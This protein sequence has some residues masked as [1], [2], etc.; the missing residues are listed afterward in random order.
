MAKITA[1]FLALGASGTIG[2]TITASRWR[3]VPYVRQRVVPANPNSAA[4]QATRNVF[5]WA[6]SVWKLAPPLIVDPWTLFAQGQPLT[7]RNGFVGRS[8]ADLRG[9]VDLADFTFTGGAKGGIPPTTAIATPAS[10]SFV[11]DFVNPTPPTGWTLVSAIAAAIADQSPAT[12][13]LFDITAGEDTPAAA[14]VTLAGLAGLTLYQV[15]GWLEWTKADGATAYSAALMA[16]ATT[17]A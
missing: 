16:P 9:D 2:K 5:S 17:L 1:P 7:N 15:G 14:Q 12:G 11:V 8:V 3:G 4:Q 10:Q 6:N 13:L